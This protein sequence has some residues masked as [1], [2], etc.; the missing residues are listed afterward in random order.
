MRNLAVTVEVNVTHNVMSI[1]YITLAEKAEEAMQAA[2]V[3][4]HND[5]PFEADNTGDN[6]VVKRILRHKDDHDETKHLL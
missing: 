3:K 5:M 2:E 6:Y 1:N 4:P